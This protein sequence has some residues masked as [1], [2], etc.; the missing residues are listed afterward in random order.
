MVVRVLWEHVVWVRFPALRPIKIFQ[1]LRTIDLLGS[2]Q[3]PAEPAQ[4]TFAFAPKAEFPAKTD[5][6]LNQRIKAICQICASLTKTPRL[7]D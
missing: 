3:C 7:T 2:Y 1:I 6:P 5:T 4:L